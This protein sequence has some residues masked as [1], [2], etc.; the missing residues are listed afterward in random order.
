[1]IIDETTLILG[2]GASHNYGLPTGIGL[3]DYLIH[4]TKRKEESR[5]P[6]HSWIRK[7]L[8]NL[9]FHQD[10]IDAFSEAFHSSQLTSIDEFL[11]RRA[12][13]SRIGKHAISL[14]IKRTENPGRLTNPINENEHWYH[15]LWNKLASG[16]NWESIKENKISIITFNYD[17]SL[18]TYLSNAM[19]H[20]FAKSIEECKEAIATCIKII[21]VYGQ[22]YG[23][24]GLQRQPDEDENKWY[25]RSF[26]EEIISKSADCIQIIPEGRDDSLTLSQCHDILEKSDKI[27]FLGFGFD[28]TNMR[29]LNLPTKGIAESVT[30]LALREVYG[31]AMGIQPR[32]AQALK[33]SFYLNDIS[34]PGYSPK[35]PPEFIDYGCRTL[36]ED[37]LVLG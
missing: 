31:T 16:T 4:G 17:R 15:Y 11:S 29:R 23:E 10:N 36:L 32:R 18:E 37:W 2:A 25:D 30:G 1:M 33:K 3:R 35:H 26:P 9:G 19:S 6:Y 20:A 21:H 13:F 28:P 22:V 24:Y 27:C 34:D 8:L 7:D 5:H 12:E 14:I